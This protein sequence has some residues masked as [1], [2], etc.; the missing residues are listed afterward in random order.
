MTIARSAEVLERGVRDSTGLASPSEDMKEEPLAGGEESN[1]CAAT[2]LASCEPVGDSSV[3][4]LVE[5]I[6]KDRRRL[7]RLIRDRARQPELVPR[8]L[9]IA[10]AGFLFYG[11]AMAI[12]LNAADVRP[13]LA[14]VEDW[15]DGTASRLIR[16]APLAGDA[17]L[18]E[19]WLHSGLLALPAAYGLG[20]IAAT[21]VC[22][23]SLY[24]YGLLSG[25][26]MSMLDV[27]VHAL[28]A[29]ATSAVALVGV[30]P[31]YAAIGMAAIVFQ[32]P[33]QA[34]EST[35]LLGLV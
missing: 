16:F 13:Q 12:V 30:L 32:V 2:G 19:R 24:F 28:K 29:K 14:P 27:T 1:H 5:L 23:P 3:A 31:V 11:L 17:G 10:L 6:L 35:M 8:F 33:P 4:A 25:V 22:L 15:L 20:L 9:A 34:L 18:V 21:G 26:R 7:H